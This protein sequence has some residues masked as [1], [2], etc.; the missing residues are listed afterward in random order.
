MDTYFNSKSLDLADMLKTESFVDLK[1][2]TD[3]EEEVI[4]DPQ[5]GYLKFERIRTVGI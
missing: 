1:I 3:E 4:P 5:L 2:F